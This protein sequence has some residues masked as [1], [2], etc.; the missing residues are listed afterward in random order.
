MREGKA[1]DSVLKRSVHRFLKEGVQTDAANGIQKDVASSIQTE[2]ATDPEGGMRC[3]FRVYN[4]LLIRGYS[5]KEAAVSILLPLDYKDPEG[6]LKCWMESVGNLCEKK[7]VRVLGGHTE[8]SRKVETGVVTIS[9]RGEGRK[10][11]PFVQGE[12]VENLANEGNWE[13][14]ENREKPLSD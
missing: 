7:K 11:F 3:F 8:F 4:D 9:G 5:M 10:S 2:L 6:L 13:N 12:N 1:K 14:E